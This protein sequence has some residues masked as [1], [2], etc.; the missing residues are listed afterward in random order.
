MQV[1][2]LTRLTN[3]HSK[4][5]RN[6]DAMLSLWFAFYN[7]CR[8]HQT[9][10]TTPAVKAGLAEEPWTLADLLVAAAA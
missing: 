1:R 2:R 7:W 5:T 4:K 9:I 10:K 3:A 8:K 6:H